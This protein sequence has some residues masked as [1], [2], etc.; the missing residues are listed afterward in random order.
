LSAQ[1]HLTSLQLRMVRGVGRVVEALVI[2]RS[3]PPLCRLLIEVSDECTSPLFLPEPPL[4]SLLMDV[5]PSLQTTLVIPE[6]LGTNQRWGP[7]RTNIA[8]EICK[9]RRAAAVMPRVRVVPP[10]L[11][12]DVWTV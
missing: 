5:A 11:N 9:L 1:V 6:R 3:S 4:L 2:T 10:S 12:P 7:L 8:D